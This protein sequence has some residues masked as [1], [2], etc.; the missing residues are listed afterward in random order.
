MR[1]LRVGDLAR[2]FRVSE[3]TVYNWVKREWLPCL[4]RKGG[5]PYTFDP[6]AVDEWADAALHRERRVLIFGMSRVFHRASC[7]YVDRITGKIIPL[8]RKEAIDA[9]YRPCKVCKP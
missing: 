6:H 5:E 8:T 3:Q 7:R 2:M 4:P 9:G 1:T